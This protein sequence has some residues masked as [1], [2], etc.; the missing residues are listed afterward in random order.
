MDG[1]SFTSQLYSESGGSQGVEVC[2]D[3]DAHLKSSRYRAS[4]SAAAWQYVPDSQLSGDTRSQFVARSADPRAA[5]IVGS[6]DSSSPFARGTYPP[7]SQPCDMQPSIG[8]TAFHSPQ[9]HTGRG[10]SSRTD[11]GAWG[12]NP[13]QSSQP[14]S[15]RP[16]CMSPLAQPVVSRGVVGGGETFVN[17]RSSPIDQGYRQQTPMGPG[18]IRYD[19]GGATA[20]TPGGG[21]RQWGSGSRGVHTPPSGD[22]RSRDG[23][24]L[25]FSHPTVGVDS[26]PSERQGRNVSNTGGTQDISARSRECSVE[27]GGSGRPPKEGGAGERRKGGKSTAAPKKN[28]LWT[29]EERVLLAKISSEDD[30]LMD[31]AEGAHSLMTRGR[32]YD[33]ISDRMKENGYART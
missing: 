16:Q 32:R 21:D 7:Q 18:T 9:P 15:H 33:W 30:A 31:D 23:E 13:Q 2:E 10:G 28:T 25:S 24:R 8:G 27:D 12:S 17:G 22:C 20:P 11:A 5:Y 14:S 29:L 3:M 19:D 6:M 1:G 4:L 26:V